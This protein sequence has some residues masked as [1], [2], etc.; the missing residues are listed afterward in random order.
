MRSTYSGLSKG[1]AHNGHEVDV[2]LWEDYHTFAARSG[3]FSDTPGVTI[4][5][6]KVC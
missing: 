2:I 4:H 1:L 3:E 6:P 5:T